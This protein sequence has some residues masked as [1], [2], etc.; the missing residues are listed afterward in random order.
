MSSESSKD[1]G[2]RAA[3]AAA[4]ADDTE[5]L[6]LVETA[7]VP[8]YADDQGQIE[9]TRTVLLRMRGLPYGANEQD[10]ETFFENYSLVAAFICRRAGEREKVFSVSTQR[11]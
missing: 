7:E 9:E 5:A 1:D 3:E 10:V 2:E 8:P 6:S 11:R 4:E